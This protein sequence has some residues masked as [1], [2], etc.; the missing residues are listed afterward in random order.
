[1][2]S[3]RS[4]FS[5]AT[6]MVIIFFLFQFTNIALEAWN[7]YDANKYAVE[8]QDLKG[9]IHAYLAGVHGDT[10][11]NAWGQ[12]RGI[13]VYVGPEGSPMEETVKNWATYTKRSM[14][15]GR[16][17][18]QWLGTPELLVVD[19]AALR[20]DWRSLS[21]E[22]AKYA[23]AGVNVVFGSLPEAE[24]IAACPE[25]Q[26]LLG[27]KE[28]LRDSPAVAGLQLYQGFLLGGEAV[29]QAGDDPEQLRRQDMDL[30]FPWYLLSAGTRC[31]LEGIP[32]DGASGERPAVI[33]RRDLESAFVF[34]V[35]GSYLSDAAGLGIL[36]AMAAESHSYSVYPVL[37]AQQ[38]VAASFPV[39]AMGN[40]AEL[41]RLYS[42]TMRGLFQDIL[43]PDMVTVQQQSRMGLTCM[44]APEL[45]YSDAATPD[46]GL[47]ISYMKAINAQ[48]A[49]AGFS[50][51]RASDTSMTDKLLSD[52]GFLEAAKLEYQFTALYGG[53]LPEK[54]IMDALGWKDLASLRTVVTADMGDSQVV[55]WQSDQVTRQ[56]VVADGLA[57]TFMGDL[58]VRAAETALGYNSLLIDIGRVVYPGPEEV[59]WEVYSQRLWQDLAVYRDR[60]GVFEGTTASQCDE[61]IRE[62][63]ALDFTE[64]LT[65]Q[66]LTLKTTGSDGP[67]WFILRTASATVEQVTGGSFQRI[68]AGAFLIRADE[69]EVTITLRGEV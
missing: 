12:P 65:G 61:R 49:E 51:D 17:L 41:N 40:S 3:R 54:E 68:E 24:K 59:T 64:E 6:I 30:S 25:L 32:E 60:F 42:R 43:W 57:N 38:I 23:E 58:R 16:N 11:E 44:V 19:A 8:V 9:R 66:T 62:M 4:F 13:V 10:G 34:A 39:L 50:G 31:Y 18:N 26:E 69:P 5:I 53:T 15:T 33:W 7:D 36:S 46:Q 27:I 14:G 28:V 56:N 21:A 45:D 35:N 20:G 29:Y 2:I 48:A 47:F 22:L 63:M 55:G 67:S 37:N 52:F 1:M